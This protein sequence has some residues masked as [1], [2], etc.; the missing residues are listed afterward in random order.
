MPS[1]EELSRIMKTAGYSVPQDA[2]AQLSS[3]VGA[4]WDG[5]SDAQSARTCEK[6][7]M[8]NKNTTGSVAAQFASKWGT[9]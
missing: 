7:A 3:C 8:G 6:G 5:A 9:K 1:R 2:A 4:L